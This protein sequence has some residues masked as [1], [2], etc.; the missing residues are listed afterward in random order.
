MA[1][2]IICQIPDSLASPTEKRAA[3]RFGLFAQDYSRETSAQVFSDV[4]SPMNELRL[5]DCRHRNNTLDTTG[6][7]APGDKTQLVFIRK[8]PCPYEYT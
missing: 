6:T 1:L 2:R 7:P 8:G 4:I 5:P 3:Y